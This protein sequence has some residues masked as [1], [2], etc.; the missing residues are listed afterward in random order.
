MKINS[1]NEEKRER[2]G[3]RDGGG[4]TVRST[5]RT[6]GIGKKAP[7]GAGGHKFEW[8]D[9]TN[10]GT[11]YLWQALDPGDPLYSSGN[12][13]D[14]NYVLVSSCDTVNPSS[15]QKNNYAQSSTG[16]K[17]TTVA[18]SIKEVIGPKYA[19][20]EFK[21]RLIQSFDE[22]YTSG[23]IYETERQISECECPE[24]AFEIVKRGVSKALD[25]KA[26]ERELTSKL[27]AAAIADGLMSWQDAAKG[28]ERLFEAM[29]DLILD[30]PKAEDI[31]A[32]FLIRCVV[33]EVL[34]PAVLIDRVFTALGGRIVQKA[35][36]VLSRDHAGAKL[37]RIWGPGDG[38]ETSD[39]KIAVDQLLQ[40]YLSAL[41]L[42][43][44]A[45]CVK[46]LE[47]P[48]FG[49]EVVKRAIT[50]ALPLAQDKHD[51]ISLLLKA[52][53]T[54]DD[55]SPSLSKHQAKLGFNK[56]FQILP[57]LILDVPDAKRKLNA[58]LDR[59]KADFLL[60]P[61]YQPQINYAQGATTTN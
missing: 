55:T 8:K 14:E 29:E 54:D 32:D 34:P 61:D 30:V 48:Q 41:D 12:E 4:A 20:A 39:L 35:T 18:G 31:V 53:A 6:R 15:T 2:I 47:A 51:A 44:A 59:A 19:L 45:R 22:L 3:P 50:T 52:L 60:P 37:E 57:D 28:F 56:L 40:E 25:R 9:K 7:S 36:R 42:E 17:L 49:H 1:S 16:K 26:H 24:F 43:E 38:R 33:D 27:F 21:R 46:E 13:E 5:T 11:T 23:D 10:D 58:F